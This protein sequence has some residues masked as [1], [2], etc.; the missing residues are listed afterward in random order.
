MVE[1][2]CIRSEPSPAV[3]R[4]TANRTSLYTVRIPN[5]IGAPH[6]NLSN[7]TGLNGVIINATTLTLLADLN[8]APFKNG[9]RVTCSEIGG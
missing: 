9:T 8:Y 7:I 2:T 1:F 3:V 6:A 5:D 4:W